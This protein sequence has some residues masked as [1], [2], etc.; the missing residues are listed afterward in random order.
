MNKVMCA[1]KI[2]MLCEYDN[3]LCEQDNYL[4]EKDNNQCEQDINI[5]QIKTSA[6][7][8]L[9]L[10]KENKLCEQ[11]TKLHERNTEQERD[12]NPA[13]QKVKTIY[14]NN[15]KQYHRR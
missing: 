3:N 10:H 8:I 15:N 14:I 1:N 4:C 9:I 12:I 2:E 13:N 11:D 7:K 6:N 5:V